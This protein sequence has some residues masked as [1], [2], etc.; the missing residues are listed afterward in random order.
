MKSDLGEPATLPG[1]Q[2]EDLRSVLP[3]LPVC[4]LVADHF[5]VW[6]PDQCSLPSN[7][8]SGLALLCSPSSHLVASTSQEVSFPRISHSV[9]RFFC[10]RQDLTAQLLLM[11][12]GAESWSRTGS[13]VLRIHTRHK[14]VTNITAHKLPGFNIIPSLTFIFYH[15]LFT[16][17]EKWKEKPL[18]T[19]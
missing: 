5:Y 4:R 17:E 12:M 10:D 6:S 15:F 8:P 2:R 19:R 13:I 14:A 1:P 9:E 16:Q 7:S 3:V 11:L 18:Y